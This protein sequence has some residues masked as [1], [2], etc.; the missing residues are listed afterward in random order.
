[1]GTPLKMKSYDSSSCSTENLDTVIKETRSKLFALKRVN[2]ST[3]REQNRTYPTFLGSIVVLEICMKCVESLHP[4]PQ[5]DSG[6]LESVQ[7]NHIVVLSLAM[8]YI[9][10]NL[11]NVL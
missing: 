11:L 2:C 5:I 3:Q 1:M 8:L 6:T 9:K 4:K 7:N 10:A